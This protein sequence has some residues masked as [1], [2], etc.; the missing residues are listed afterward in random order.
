MDNRINTSPAG[1]AAPEHTD[2]RR[3]GRAADPA[4][5]CR[6]PQALFDHLVAAAER[7]GRSRNSE[8]LDR[9][10]RTV[11]QDDGTGEAEHQ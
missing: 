7:A 1:E 10:W 6:M 8:L 2:I 5:I 11:Q 4:M 9:L 3:R